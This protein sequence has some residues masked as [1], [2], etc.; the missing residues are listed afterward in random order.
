MSQKKISET[1]IASEKQEKSIS[2]GQVTSS[3]SSNKDQRTDI[4]NL[5]REILES[6][7]YKNLKKLHLE[8][9]IGGILSEEEFW[10]TRKSIIQ[11][12]QEGK[13]EAGLTPKVYPRFILLVLEIK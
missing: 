8:L 5:R 6:D 7:K 12:H 4:Y 9:V 3:S 2:K 11:E 1:S 13:Q 10:E